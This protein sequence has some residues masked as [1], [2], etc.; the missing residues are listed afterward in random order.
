MSLGAINTIFSPWYVQ[1]GQLVR[2][3]RMSRGLSQTELAD[4]VGVT[5]QQVQKYESGSNRIPWDGSP[6]LR[7]YSEFRCRTSSREAN[8]EP[9]SNRAHG[10]RPITRMPS[11][12]LGV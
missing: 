11:K 2:V 8:S 3:L 1:V 6:V 4:R 10:L 7:N 5:F 9:R 12:C